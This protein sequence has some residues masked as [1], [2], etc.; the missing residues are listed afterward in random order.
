MKIMVPIDFSENSILALETALGLA[1]RLNSDLRMVYV[2]PAGSKYAKGL[3][4][5]TDSDEHPQDKLEKLLL[6]YRQQYAVKGKFDYK[7]LS[8]NVAEELVNVAKYDQVTLIVTGSHGV[9]GISQNW[10]G[11]NAFKL[12]CNATCPVLVIRQGMTFDKN[13]RRVAIPIT[14]KKSSRRMMPT[15]AG[16]A[17]LFGAKAIVVGLQSSKLKYIY[18]RISISVGQVASYLKSHDVEVESTTMLVGK[19]NLGSLLEIVKTQ[20]ADM[21]MMDVTNSGSFITDRLFRPE[22]TTIINNSSSP[23]LTIP[24][25]E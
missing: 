7:M 5:H 21:V 25:K 18:N 16:L 4:D 20:K 17:K 6:D 23:I 11:G 9:S 12:I 14:I 13:F 19:D 22:L 8:G 15:V 24:V 10:I 1:N 2:T 3:E